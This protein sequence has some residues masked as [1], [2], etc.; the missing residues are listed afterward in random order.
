[1]LGALTSR[2]RA[3]TDALLREARFD[4]ATVHERHSAGEPSP[5]WSNGSCDITVLLFTTKIKQCVPFSP[6]HNCSFK[7]EIAFCVRGVVSPALSNIVLNELDQEL[8]RRGHRFTRYAEDCNIY[9]R[10][11]RAGERVMSSVT[12]LLTTKLKLRV[13]SEKRAVARPWERKLL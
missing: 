10:S 4:A 11:R 1:M 12:R 5:S 2:T 3:T 6:P 13:N 8:E 7:L 9:V